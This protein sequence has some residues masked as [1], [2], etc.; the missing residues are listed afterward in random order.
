MF[1][2]VSRRQPVIHKKSRTPQNNGIRQLK[3]TFDT[4]INLRSFDNFARFNAAGAHLHPA[5]A[6]R[7]ELNTDGLQVRIEAAAR[8]V[9]SV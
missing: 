3:E 5:I 7:R 8:L 4:Q 2:G 1:F 6:A 9:I